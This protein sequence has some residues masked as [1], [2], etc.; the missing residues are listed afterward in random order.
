MPSVLNSL[1][2]QS[3]RRPAIYTRVDA[4]ALAGGALESGN[5]A[6]VG[7]FPTFASNTPIQFS[8]RRSMVDYDP[9]D[10]ELSMLAQLSFDPSDDPAVSSGASSVR[11][12]NA[13]LGAVAASFTFGALT[14][15]SSIY[16]P[17]SNSTRG[18][19]SI[20]GD[21]HTLVID[22]GGRSESF[23]VENN[24]LATVTNNKAADLDFDCV[25]GVITISSG[26]S[27]LLTITENEAPDLRTA[28]ILVNQ[29]EDVE[30]V[31]VEPRS[32]PLSELD[33]Q[34]HTI[35]SGGGALSLKAP[36]QALLNELKASKLVSS[37]I[38]TSAAGAALASSTVYA[39]GG[40][41]GG[42]HD[43]VGALAQTEALNIQIL[44]MF[45]FM[46]GRQILLQDHLKA[47]ASAGYERQAYISIEQSS[48]LGQVRA[49][50]AKFNAADVAL[51]SQDITLYDARGAIVEKDSRFTALMLAGMQAGSDIGEPL[52]RKRPRII[53]FKQSWS[54][55]NDAEQALQSG[56]VFL[57][58]GPVGPR[59]ERSITTH[60]EDNNPILSEISAYESVITSLRDLRVSL[61]DQIGRPT[62]ASQMSLISARVTARLTAQV[63]DGMIKRFENVTLEDLGDQVAVSYDLA[64]LEPLNFITITAITK[65]F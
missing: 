22:R 64:P 8:S 41:Q 21:T 16:G 4:S 50:A 61:A 53:S 46:E 9:D 55:H 19:L 30:A 32:I 42:G 39:S 34:D 5:I 43:Y 3:T 40:A 25:S 51:T 59:V 18:T 10:Q 52:T 54:S 11:V 63:R 58:S 44:V 49:R 24:V 56:T 47:A 15:T 33:F 38:D 26:G 65:R 27:T 57:T 60:L 62:Q 37:T 13:R 36:N 17:R 20:N 48:T 45:D 6:I 7:D 2:F 12:V 31:L 1:G 23:E 35:A 14:C 29:L 28:L